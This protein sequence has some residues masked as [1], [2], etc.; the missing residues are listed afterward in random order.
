VPVR[1]VLAT[2]MAAARPSAA[3]SYTVRQSSTKDWP[4]A[5]HFF[6]DVPVGTSAIELTLAV[7]RGHVHTEFSDGT[8]GY[9]I[10]GRS[11]LPYRYSQTR[12]KWID[13]PNTAVQIVADPEPGTME[14]IVQQ[15][16]N[17]QFGGDSATYHVPSEV[18]LSVTARRVN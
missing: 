3:N 14:V 15:M 16:D 6:V 12:A 1:I 5:H 13:A 9:Y 7:K 4:H 17:P 8:A 18:E 2:V 10:M 11:S